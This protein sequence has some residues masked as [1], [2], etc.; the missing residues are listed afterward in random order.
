MA[1]K[2]KQIEFSVAV[3]CNVKLDM[4]PCVTEQ[5]SHRD[6]KSNDAVWVGHMPST[7]C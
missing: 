4:W 2:Q 3:T 7:F 6:R 5:A 1:G